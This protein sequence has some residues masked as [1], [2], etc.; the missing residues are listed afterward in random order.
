MRPR[1]FLDWARTPGPL[2]SVMRPPPPTKKRP[3]EI[4]EL[5]GARGIPVLLIVLFHYHEWFGYPGAPW[6][7]TIASKGYIWV[8]FFFALSGFIL[9]Y[10]YGSRFGVGLKAE[11]IG[12]FL[13]ARVSRIY[14]LQLVTLLAVVIL[15]I[16]RRIARSRQLGVSLFNVPIFEGRNSGHRARLALRRAS[17]GRGHAQKDLECVGPGTR[18]LVGSSARTATSVRP[19]APQHSSA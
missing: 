17:Y 3:P 10:A 18:P 15:E 16:D 4:R 11:A 6:Y 19:R 7:D 1:R 12:A 13:A 2:S 9:F 14:P 8:E 5:T